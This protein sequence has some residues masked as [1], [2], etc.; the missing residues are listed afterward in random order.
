MITTIKLTHP[1]PQIVSFF[2]FFVVRRFKT[3]SENFKFAKYGIVTYS[4]HTVH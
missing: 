4:H 3:Y 1:S 2:F